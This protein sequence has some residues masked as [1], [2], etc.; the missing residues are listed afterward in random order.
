M[1]MDSKTYAFID[2]SGNSNLDTS[3]NGVSKYF[4]IAAIIVSESNL[5]KLV[6]EVESLRDIYFQSGEMKSSGVAN[7]KSRRAKILM[8]LGRLNFKFYALCLNKERVYKD[9]GLQYKQSFIKHVN[10][11]LYNSL[12][13]TY[14]DLH[15]IA[16]EHGSDEFK[17]GFKSYIEKNHKPDLFYKSKFDFVDSKEF[18]LVQLSDF[19]AGT[20]AKIYEKN[21]SDEL[22]E[23]YREFLSTRKALSITEWP[24]QYQTYHPKD[25]TSEEFSKLIHE[26][27]LSRAEA[28][29]EDN[30]KSQELDIQMQVA[31]LRHLV[32][33]SRIL[34][35]E[36]YISTDQIK[37]FLKDSGFAAVSTHAV[38]LKIVGPLRDSKVIVTSSNKGYKIP[39]S[40]KDMEDFVERVQ[41]IVVPLLSRLSKARQSL[42]AVSGDEVDILKGPNYSEL[43]S[44]LHVIE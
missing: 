43:V 16:D 5:D 40:F 25:D 28:Y 4:I 10:G 38:R 35:K 6:K 22:S 37:T 41:S 21:T 2:E 3:K 18:T 8:A 34:K 20:L 23:A 15:I 44:F 26:F 36:D 29:I 42:K 32:F 27:A 33:Q 17:K 39:C 19:I 9:S 31:F 30:E 7:N 24:T 12:Y 13:R 1:K 11:K 14:S